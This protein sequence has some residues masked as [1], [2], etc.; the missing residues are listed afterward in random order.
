MRLHCI[1]KRIVIVD[2]GA[3]NILSI[4]RKLERHGIRSALGSDPEQVASADLLIFP[5]VGHFSAAMAHLSKSGLIDVLNE[6]VL[7]QKT[8]ILGICLGMQLFAKSSEEGGAK[9]LG[10]IDA[11]V[12]KFRR[13]VMSSFRRVPHV[14]WNECRVKRP[15]RLFEN[16]DPSQRYYFTHSYHLQCADSSDELGKTVY[17]YEFTSAVQRENIF[18]VQFHPEKSHLEGLRVLLDFARL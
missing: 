11:H 6:K 3:G 16:V 15:C 2:Y 1:L 12:V 10:W 17:G 13:E 14:G 8:P 18:G 7:S 5:G 4:Q 9:G